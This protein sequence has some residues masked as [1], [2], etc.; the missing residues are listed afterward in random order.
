MTTSRL[1]IKPQRACRGWRGGGLGEP[2]P[3][4][5]PPAAAPGEPW[6]LDSRDVARL[7]GIGRTKTYQMMATG[8]LPVVRIGRCARVPRSALQSWIGDRTTSRLYGGAGATRNSR[9][10]EIDFDRS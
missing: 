6:L 4:P 8:Q 5:V 2:A 10:F 1:P 7:L 3:H 9:A